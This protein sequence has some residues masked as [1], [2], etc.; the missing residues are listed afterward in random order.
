M[1]RGRWMKKNPANQVHPGEKGNP[2]WDQIKLRD[3]HV[4]PYSLRLKEPISSR[5]QLTVTVE[6]IPEVRIPTVTQPSSR[7]N[8]R[9]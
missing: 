5:Y 2:L 7:L 8:L 9:F 1:Q 6:T 3:R 4:H